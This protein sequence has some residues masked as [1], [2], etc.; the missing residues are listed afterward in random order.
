[1]DLSWLTGAWGQFSAALKRHPEKIFFG[2]MG[3][4]GAGLLLRDIEPFWAVGLPLFLSVLYLCGRIGDN[5]HKRHMAQVSLDRLGKTTGKQVR[6]KATKALE[7][8]K[9]KRK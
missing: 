9:A 6:A 8:R 2:F 3:F 1:V 5:L 7:H 4:R